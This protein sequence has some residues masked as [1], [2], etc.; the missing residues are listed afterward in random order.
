MANHHIYRDLRPMKNILNGQKVF[1][2]K[3]SHAPYRYTLATSV[4]ATDEQTDT[5]L[6]KLKKE[7]I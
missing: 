7:R 6:T 2:K 5:I 4:R 3:I 1:A